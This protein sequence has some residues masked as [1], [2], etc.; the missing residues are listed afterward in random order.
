[1]LKFLDMVFKNKYFLFLLHVSFAYRI[2]FV[3][4]YK[5]HVKSFSWSTFAGGGPEYF[6]QGLDPL[7]ATLLTMCDALGHYF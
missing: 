5:S 3:H 6:E 2:F 7:L 1:M 4:Q